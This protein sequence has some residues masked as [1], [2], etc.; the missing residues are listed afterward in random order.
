[1][2]QRSGGRGRA[3]VAGARGRRR[4]R[5][6]RGRAAARPGARRA[7][8]PHVRRASRRGVDIAVV[9][10]E[11]GPLARARSARLYG[12][13][14]QSRSP[15]S[16]WSAVEQ[17]VVAAGGQRAQR[18]VRAAGELAVGQSVRGVRAPSRARRRAR[19]RRARARPARQPPVPVAPAPARTRRAG[20]RSAPGRSASP[21]G[22]R[23]SRLPDARRRPRY[24]QPPRLD[25]R[26]PPGSAPPC[27]RRPCAARRR[28][29]LR[30]PAPHP[31]RRPPSRSR[32][33]RRR[34]PGPPRST[35]TP[36]GVLHPA[37]QAG[38]L[39]DRVV[40]PHAA[41]GPSARIAAST[42]MSPASV[43]PGRDER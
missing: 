29:R 25:V 33:A 43:A 1:M 20:T 16:S 37:P 24:H 5:R 9:A 8:P 10:A 32:R 27:R 42:A 38:Q 35:A 19:A 31:P 39:G 23:C 7:A 17:G 36:P 30:P 18:V 3:A 14:S 4:R 26:T 22:S 15:A 12:P 40:D 6:R 13:R 34:Q 11:L 28:C 41:P 21:A 2:G